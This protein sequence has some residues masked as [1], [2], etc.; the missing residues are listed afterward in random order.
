MIN[1][2][3]NFVRLSGNGATVD[4]AYPFRV[5]S[6]SHIRVFLNGALLSD[7]YTINTSNSTVTFNSAPNSGTENVVLARETD[8][9]QL[10]QFPEGTK[11]P[12][13]VVESSFDWNT[14]TE[15]DLRLATRRSLRLSIP[16][17]IGNEDF[18][19]D[20]SA[21]ARAGKT[22][23][24]TA[25]GQGITLGPTADQ[26]SLAQTYAEAAQ[27]YME[28]AQDA[29]N[30]S[31]TVSAI[32][33]AKGDLLVAS[34]N[35]TLAR[36]AVGTNG[37]VLAANSSATLG[38]SWETPGSFITQLPAGT[39]YGLHIDNSATD[40]TNDIDI[41]PG[42]AVST[43]DAVDRVLL[44]LSGAIGKRLDATWSTGHGNG[45]RSSSVALANTTYHIFLIRVSGVDDIGADTDADAT[46]LIADHSVTHYR[47]IFSIVRSAGSIRQFIHARD[48]V[49]WKV[50]IA[51]WLDVI[52]ST[53]TLVQLS[54]PSGISPIAIVNISGNGGTAR[55]FNVYHP[56]QTAAA[57][58]TGLNSAPGACVAATYTDA[59][60]VLRFAARVN[61]PTSSAGQIR[62]SS[63]ASSVACVT[64]QGYIDDRG[65]IG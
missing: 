18:T 10:T 45:M 56:D 33:N 9:V 8:A 25:S 42:E 43:D 22:I 20:A 29:A 38:V 7:G 34:A 53:G 39:I 52:A 13:G 55:G 11:F 63:I 51:D 3:V 58:P 57:V 44:S 64:T 16:S 31:E 24:F 2:T 30:S 27:T 50:P 12:S 60:D 46:N 26:I 35:D 48:Y 47:R 15:Q 1:S 21:A 41:Q 17:Y 32:A 6:N 19:L 49:Y 65:R 5:M 23:L 14:L 59:S 28:A 61:V 54:V 4:F 40:A 62:L 37:K 36:L